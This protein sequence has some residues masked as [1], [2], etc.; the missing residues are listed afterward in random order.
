MTFQARLEN[1]AHANNFRG[2]G[3]LSVALVITEQVKIGTSTDSL[4]FPLNPEAFL[5]SGGG[6]VL[7][8]GRDAVQ[9]VLK[10]HGIE[11][12]LA[13][14]GGR[15]SRGS[16]GKMRAYVEFLNEAHAHGDLNLDAAMSWWIARVNEFFAAKPLTMRL[17]ASFAI[18]TVVRDLLKQADE[19]Q[20]Q[21]GG[22]MIVGTVMQHLVGAK[23]DVA[24]AGK[25]MIEH[26]GANQSDQQTGR[27]ADF[28]I[29]D[30]AIHVTTSPSEALIRKCEANLAA[31]LKPIIVSTK[32][33][34][35]LADGLAANAGIA[36]AIDVVEI[37]QFM[38]TN[39]HELGGFA[40]QGRNETIRRIVRRYNEIVGSVE[41]DPGL[42]IDVG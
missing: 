39:V 36:D 9:A 41:T 8:L 3:P 32:N 14:E 31:N 18:R 11:R 15:T 10:S 17:N 28:D 19:R 40:S 22:T 24:M 23:L 38:A 29:G 21:G 13:A 27:A 16:I 42:M 6:Q 37:G 25:V 33:G 34:A 7:G 2:K 20:R 1:F 35:T 26:H 4:S 5:T 12:L 30:A